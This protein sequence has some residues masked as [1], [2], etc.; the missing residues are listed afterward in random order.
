MFSLVKTDRKW[1]DEAITLSISLWYRSTGEKLFNA[2]QTST[3][4]HAIA[5]PL[6]VATINSS[7]F[8]YFSYYKKI[9]EFTMV[10]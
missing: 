4:C 1:E 8:S 3:S 5:K 9:D 6:L 10:S 2:N 7:I